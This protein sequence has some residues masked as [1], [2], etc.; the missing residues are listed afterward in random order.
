MSGVDAAVA[1]GIADQSRLFVAG[2]SAGGQL[3]AWTVGRTGRFRAAAVVKPVI[4]EISDALLTDQFAN[5]GDAVGV[6]PW[7]DPMAYWRRSPLSL[8]G[9]VT[10][11]TL[12]MV[13]EEDHRTPIGEAQQYFDALQFRGVPSRLVVFPGAGHASINGTPSRLIA[14][15]ALQL[16]WFARYGG[17]PVSDAAK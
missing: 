1:A 16:D 7:N 12:V 4:N 14:G 8:V 2:G 13:G 17:L 5:L 9:H 11:P 3:A 15:V 6:L 10:T